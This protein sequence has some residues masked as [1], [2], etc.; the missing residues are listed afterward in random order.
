MTSET[1]Q[2][3]V[4]DRLVA[5]EY[6]FMGPDSAAGWGLPEL[7]HGLICCS[8]EPAGTH[9]TVATTDLAYWQ[10]VV[11]ALSEENHPELSPPLII[12]PDMFPT[13]RTGWPGEWT[14]AADPAIDWVR[15]W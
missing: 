12:P 4:A 3:D 13:L 1:S 15:R 11:E 9:V 7:A 2:T 14:P 8:L 5:R 10:M 6:A